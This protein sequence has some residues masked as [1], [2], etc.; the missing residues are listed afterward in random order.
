MSE[1]HPY[2]GKHLRIGMKT[3]KLNG[4]Y[5]ITGDIAKKV[6]EEKDVG[7]T[8]DENLMFEKHIAEKVK[9]WGILRNTFMYMSS[10]ITVPLYKTMVR[11]HL[12]Y[13]SQF[14]L[15]TTLQETYRNER[16]RSKESDKVA[17]RTK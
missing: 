7:V 1:F 12:H 15:V 9:M 13:A 17:T 5:K 4:K 11:S 3:H 8:F 2:K 10:S 14:S 16:R 6:K